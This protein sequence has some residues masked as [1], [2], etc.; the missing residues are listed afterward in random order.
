M[1]RAIHFHSDQRFLHVEAALLSRCIYR[2]K[3]KFRN[4]KDFKSLEKI[5]RILLTYLEMN[6]KSTLKTFYGLVPPEVGSICTYLPT[7]NILNY[8]LV[9]LQGLAKLMCR[10]VETTQI[11]LEHFKERIRL[12]HF[13][14][15]ALIG[16]GIASRLHVLAKRILSNT[17][18][19]YDQMHQYAKKLKNGKAAEWL[20][21]D[22]ILPERL[23]EWLD[24]P[25][26]EEETQ[27]VALTAAREE[28]KS[29]AVMD[30][31]EIINLFNSSDSD[32]D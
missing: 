4:C 22:Y 24:I 12:G 8:V 18:N 26:E 19:V 25:W 17:C 7:K 1:Q 30:F 32:S 10:L 16:S 2:M 28:H 21:E 31:S 9:R 5:N 14:Y 3:L 6:I 23:I 11:A 20:P 13:W 15:L 27:M 29:E